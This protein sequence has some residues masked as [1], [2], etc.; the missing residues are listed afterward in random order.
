MTFP[1]LFLAPFDAAVLFDRTCDST[2]TALSLA[3]RFGATKQPNDRWKHRDDTPDRSHPP[4]WLQKTL[5][6]EAVAV[7]L[8]QTLPPLRDT[9]FAM[10]I[11]A[12]IVLFHPSNSSPDCVAIVTRI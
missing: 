12:L 8:R 9:L 6:P 10:A 5:P 11:C 2:D 1:V 3:E 7:G 4:Q